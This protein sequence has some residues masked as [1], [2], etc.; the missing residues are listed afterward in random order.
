[1]R[2]EGTRSD[3]AGVGCSV[4]QPNRSS[5]NCSRQTILSPNEYKTEANTLES[6]SEVHER[7]HGTHAPAVCR[8]SERFC[9]AG[10]RQR[11]DALRQRAHEYLGGRPQTPTPRIARQQ[12]FNLV[13]GI[14][15]TMAIAPRLSVSVFKEQAR[16][17]LQRR[18]VAFPSTGGT[19]LSSP[20]PF[21]PPLYHSGRPGSGV[22]LR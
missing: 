8:A 20:F 10:S 17:L 3:P 9:E 2:T 16:A 14:P 4:N 22:P 6:I 15:V 21:R 7:R 5:Y 19:L 11:G 1:M 12:P 13:A 18:K